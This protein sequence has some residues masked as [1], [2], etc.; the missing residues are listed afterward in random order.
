[1]GMQLL[2]FEC[3]KWTVWFIRKSHSNVWDSRWETAQKWLN[4]P[5]K[6][7]DMVKVGQDTEQIYK[8]SYWE[9]WRNQTKSSK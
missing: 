3:L 5:S 7:F 8:E 2:T 1:M 6:L 4:G 9:C